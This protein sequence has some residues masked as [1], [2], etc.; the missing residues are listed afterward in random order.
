M[1]N[2]RP[3]VFEIGAL[4]ATLALSTP[5]AAQQIEMADHDLQIGARPTQLA[6]EVSEYTHAGGTTIVRSDSDYHAITNVPIDALAMVFLNHDRTGAY[7]PNL[8]EYEWAPLPGAEENV[9]IEMQ[10]I[11]V[12]FMGIDATYQIRQRSEATDLRDER[13]RR[14]ILEYEMIESLDDKLE[15]SRGTFLLEEMVI[16]GRPATY[17]RQRN[18][19][20]FRDPFRGFA[21]VLRAFAPGG[22]RRLFRAMIEEAERYTPR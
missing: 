2:L 22:T 13:P 1:P 10:R 21:A 3:R 5:L 4:V 15:S 7:L 19:T 16:D 17:M 12:R 14:F 8:H 9:V 18:S 20:E 11:G 6:F